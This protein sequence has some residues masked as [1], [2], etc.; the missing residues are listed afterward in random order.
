MIIKDLDIKSM[1]ISLSLQVLHDFTIHFPKANAD[2]LK[3]KWPE[4][5]PKMK[6]VLLDSYNLTFVT[7]WNEDIEEIFA[8]FKV[9]PAKGGK[10]PCIT[11]HKVIER[12]IFHSKVSNIPFART[13][14]LYSIWMVFQIN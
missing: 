10:S 9:L 14:F 1:N 13:I 12:F 8:L 7:L 11:F 4:Y 6:Q 5:G 3:N 2:G